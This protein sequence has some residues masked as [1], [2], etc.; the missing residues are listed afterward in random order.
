MWSNYVQ[1]ETV[2]S[3]SHWKCTQSMHVSVDG[4]SVYTHFI[5]HINTSIEVGNSVDQYSL[6]A[7][8]YGPAHK[9]ISDYMKLYSVSIDGSYIVFPEKA[10]HACMCIQIKTCICMRAW[11]HWKYIDMFLFTCMHACSVYRVLQ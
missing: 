9:T 10:V 11:C 2:Y 3:A 5:V 6:L 1:P 4:H 8:I 7:P